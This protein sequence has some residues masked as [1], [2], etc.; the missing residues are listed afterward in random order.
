MRVVS[1]RQAAKTRSRETIGEDGAAVREARQLAAAEAGQVDANMLHRHYGLSLAHVL[2]MPKLEAV[3]LFGGPN[4]HAVDAEKKLCS[5]SQPAPL[6]SI[7]FYLNIMATSVIPVG[8]PSAIDTLARH[9][10]A[11]L[12]SLLFLPIARIFHLIDSVTD[13]VSRLS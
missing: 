10:Y 4:K 3:D 11:T 12:L 13:L 7:H 8:F 9:Y 6:P 2:L 1:F 5:L